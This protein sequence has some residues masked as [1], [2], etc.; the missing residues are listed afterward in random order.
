MNVLF[1]YYLYQI[2]MTHSI[3]VQSLQ[4]LPK[5]AASLLEITAKHQHFIFLGEMGTG[6]T[7]LIKEI[8][9]LLGV[10]ET[11]SSPTYS[12]VN[13]YQA[14]E[15]KAYHFDL[16]RL[17]SVEELL[18]IGFED[19]LYEDAYLFIEWPQ[20]ALDFLENYA[21]IT[22]SLQEKEQRLL[23]IEL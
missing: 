19:Y 16:Y 6:K 7:T 10:Q 5:V 23:E 18:N 15:K 8:C 1:L 20:K 9:R 22:L 11:V 17:K 21:Q 14:K 2:T 3:V 13:E 12:I 4:D